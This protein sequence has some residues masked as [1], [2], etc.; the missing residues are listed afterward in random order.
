MI[1]LVCLLAS[2][3]YVLYQ[4]DKQAIEEAQQT[5]KRIEKKLLS[6]LLEK[7]ARLDLSST[8][9]SKSLWNEMKGIPGSCIQFTNNRH[10]E[11]PPCNNE[12]TTQSSPTWFST[13]YQAWFQ[14]NYEA[15]RDVNF[16]VFTYGTV[17]VSLNVQTEISRAWKN[18][19]SI[20]S[21]LIVSLIAVCS[22]VYL[23]INRVLK[24]AQDIVAGLEKMQAGDLSTRLPNFDINEWRRTG[25]AINQLAIN[26]EKTTLENQQ[27]AFKLLHI[28]EEEHR[29][30]AR[31]LHDEF[32]QCLSGINALTSSINQN[33]GLNKNILRE[34]TKIKEISQQMMVQLRNI[35]TRLRPAE[36]DTLGLTIS[37]KNL[38]QSWEG[39][40]NNKTQ[41]QTKIN[42]DVDN[43]PEPLPINIYRIIQE[44]LTNIEKHAQAST[45]EISLTQSENKVFLSITDNGVAAS[46]SFDH[47][48]GFGLLGMR[49]RVIALGGQFII[50]P[51]QPTG[52]QIQIT[53]PINRER[54]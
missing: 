1:A 37:L 43:L 16:N 4:T 39:K 52:L 8:F 45:A 54:S 50:E 31:E 32:G 15:T 12:K 40:S 22:L 36:I 29:Y 11:R 13:L 34:S 19:K 30:I 48:K 28:Q 49:E 9:P 18:L 5:S 53:L 47:A 6:Q 24:P 20:L 25:N 35:L 44:G 10:Q 7:H 21:V 17:F 14:P 46:N 23:T 26:Q 3:Y 27:L 41:Y 42:G 33:T 2:A 38:I 51:Q